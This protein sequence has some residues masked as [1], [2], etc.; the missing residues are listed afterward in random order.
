MSVHYDGKAGYHSSRKSLG[1]VARSIAAE[2]EGGVNQK[3]FKSR[4]IRDNYHSASFFTKVCKQIG[5]LST[6]EINKM[7]AIL[8]EG[9]D[10]IPGEVYCFDEEKMYQLLISNAICKKICENSGYKS[11]QHIIARFD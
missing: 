7:L 4:F 2:E 1:S 5:N 10:H 3:Y 11:W 9:V 6:G 8:K